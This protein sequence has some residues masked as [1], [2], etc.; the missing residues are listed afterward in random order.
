MTL[1]KNLVSGYYFASPL[2]EEK[3]RKKFPA[4]LYKIC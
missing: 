2:S 3:A 1:I 4:R